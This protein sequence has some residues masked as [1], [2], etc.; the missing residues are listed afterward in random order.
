VRTWLLSRYD[1]A[2]SYRIEVLFADEVA[3]EP[4]EGRALR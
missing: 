4:A 1:D 3:R 2:A